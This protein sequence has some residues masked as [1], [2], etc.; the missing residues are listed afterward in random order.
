MA[1]VKSSPLSVRV[2]DYLGQ[3]AVAQGFADFAITDTFG[4]AHTAIQAW[5]TAL[6]AVTGAVIEQCFYKNAVPLPGG[7]K[8]VPVVGAPNSVALSINFTNAQDKVA[9]DFT[10]PAIDPVNIS[11][12]GPDMTE[13]ATID[14]L[15]DIMEADLAGTTGG[16]FTTASD[17]NL[18]L[19]YNGR[20]AVRTHRKQLQSKSSRVGA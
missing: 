17:G 4:A 20:L 14:L 9:Y 11:A 10:I 18:V 19:G 5:I 16:H 2:K 6:D 3:T 15:V 12:G 8:T 13:G 7:L 1:D